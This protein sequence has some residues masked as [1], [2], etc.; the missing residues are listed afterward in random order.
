MNRETKLDSENSFPGNANRRDFLLTA[1]GLLLAGAAP[2]RAQTGVTKVRIALS[3][4]RGL[5]YYD[6]VGI[7]IARGETVHWTAL[8][9]APSVTAFH[10]DNDNHELRIPEGAKPFDSGMLSGG[11]TFQWTFDVEGT[12]DYFSKYHEGV[13][14]IGRIVV[15]RP[16]G[17]GEKPPR[18]GGAE[19]RA[20]IYAI[21]MRVFGILNSK[22]IVERK[23]VAF[24]VDK[25]AQG[26]MGRRR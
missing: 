6:P 11:D 20:P 24:P 7:Y 18:Y 10:P 4:D 21:G 15:G 22:E 23:S 13:G 1:A 2:L 16:G 25:L 8:R 14:L 26:R 9:G 19:G 12:Y 3:Y 17:P 5:W